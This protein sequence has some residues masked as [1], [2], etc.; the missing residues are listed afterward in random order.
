MSGGRAPD[1]PQDVGRLGMRENLW[2]AVDERP[3]AR[4][5]ARPR[6]APVGQVACDPYREAFRVG[7]PGRAVGAH[8]ELEVGEVVA[9][10]LADH[11]KSGAACPDPHG[12]G[13]RGRLRA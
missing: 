8:D 5:R 13:A 7:R 9:L 1:Y 2:I 11:E 10:V 4:A 3:P 6:S 12:R